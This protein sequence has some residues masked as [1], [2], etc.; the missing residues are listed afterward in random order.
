MEI[1]I[2]SQVGKRA[3]IISPTLLKGMLSYLLGPDQP[4]QS[5]EHVPEFTLEDEFPSGASFMLF[6]SIGSFLPAAEIIGFLEPGKASAKPGQ[7]YLNM[8]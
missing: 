7:A 2:N 1:L 8:T 3:H 6:L 4:P 5:I